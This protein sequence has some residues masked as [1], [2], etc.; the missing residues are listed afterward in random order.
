VKLALFC[1]PTSVHPGRSPKPP[2]PPN[3]FRGPAFSFSHPLFPFEWIPPPEPLRPPLGT[4]G[5]KREKM[6]ERKRKSGTSSALV[7]LAP[8]SGN[9]A[10]IRCCWPDIVRSTAR[11][12]LVSSA[13]RAGAPFLP[14]LA[15]SGRPAHCLPWAVAQHAAVGPIVVYPW[16]RAGNAGIRTRG[17]AGDAGP[18]KWSWSRWR[19]G[20]V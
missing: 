19:R 3:D 12:A 4:V 10:P 18:R 13:H 11:H 1:P 7:D 9:V 20:T 14:L 5:N 16:A 17:S 8:R 15:E 2:H 6:Q